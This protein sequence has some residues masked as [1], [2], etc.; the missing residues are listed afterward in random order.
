MPAPTMCPLKDAVPLSRER[1]GKGNIKKRKSFRCRE[2]SKTHTFHP[3]L[4]PNDACL[5]QDDFWLSQPE[6]INLI[7]SKVL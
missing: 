4:W 1:R 7:D 2:P 5:D 6:I 3:T